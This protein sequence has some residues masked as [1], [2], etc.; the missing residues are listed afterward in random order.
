MQD[1]VVTL[2]YFDRKVG[3]TVF[4]EYPEHIGEEEKMTLNQIFDQ[5]TNEGFFSHSLNTRE[6]ATSLN[7][8][9]EIKSD[10]AR[11]LKEMLMCSLLFKEKV[12]SEK[13]H[14]V[15]SW[16]TDFVMKMHGRPDIFKAFYSTTTKPS[17]ATTEPI[18]ESGAESNQ[19]YVLVL[20]WLKELYY[21]T[22][23][24]VR[25]KSEEEV[26]ANLMVNPAIYE[27]IQKLSKYPVRI[28]ELKKWFDEMQFNRDFDKIIS[29]LEEQKF[30]FINNIGPETFV[31]L[32]K[33]ITVFRVPP[34][35]FLELYEQR[36][37]FSQEFIQY[38]AA[39]VSEY[40]DSYD[41]TTDDKLKLYSIMSMPKH[42]NLIAEL[43][44]KPLPKSQ[45]TAILRQGPAIATRI[46]V[47][48]DLKKENIIDEIDL[49]GVQYLFLKTDINITDQFPEYIQ[50]ALPEHEKIGR[51]PKKISIKGFSPEIQEELKD[52]FGRDEF[53]IEGE[54][55]ENMLP[56]GDISAQEQDAIESANELDDSPFDLVVDRITK[57]FIGN[58]KDHDKKESQ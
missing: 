58:K 23:E 51:M 24:E 30:I 29:L 32:V 18:T 53:I 4:L 19:N 27:T 33:G 49:S 14:E 42:Y 40:F 39:T 47:I 7:Y 13:E 26:V 1:L 48:E 54:T 11:G 10:W 41:E 38:Y 5:T 52:V 20:K 9:F 17:G 50:N 44:K 12:T 22:K 3:P 16:I 37:E 21:S 35:A 56:D 34:S 15:L 31:I 6:F 46:N 55:A 8:Y 43:R 36:D 45:I 2:S 28:G 25:Q 57:K